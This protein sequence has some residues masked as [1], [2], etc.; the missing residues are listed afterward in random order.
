MRFVSRALSAALLAG[1]TLPAIGC[2][3]VNQ[4]TSLAT[5]QQA[6]TVGSNTVNQDNVRRGAGSHGGG[7]GGGVAG[8]HR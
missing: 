1:A 5:M 6:S 7:A 8:G 4:Q 3:P 2:T